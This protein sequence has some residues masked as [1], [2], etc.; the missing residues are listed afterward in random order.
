MDY[1]EV[2]EVVICKITKVLNYGAFAELTDYENVKG[3]IPINQVASG[4]IKNIRNHIK[5]NQMRAAKVLHINEEKQQIDLSLTRVTPQQ[6][7]QELEQWKQFK[8]TKVCLEQFAKQQEEDTDEIWEEIAE[9]LMEEYDSLY[10]AFQKML[11]GD[12]KWKKLIPEKYQTEFYEFIKKSIPT[13]EKELK[14]TIE[15]QS[16]KGNGIEE[17]R[18]VLEKAEKIEGTKIFYSGA[19]KYAVSSKATTY[20]KAEQQMKK[21]SEYVTQEMKKRNNKMEFKKIENK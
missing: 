6:Q 7:R 8:R 1:P 10:E 11:V 17:I 13:P 20:K 3:F 5:D 4:W 12:E 19:G 18:E 14:G 9:P 15:I 2:G 16:I 21:L